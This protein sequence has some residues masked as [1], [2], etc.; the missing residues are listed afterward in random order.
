MTGP[1]RFYDKALVEAVD[2]GFRLT[3]DG[4]SIRT[5][6]RAPV[7]LPTR[8]LADAMAAEWNAQGDT[9]D[10]RTMPVTRFANA[11]LD[12]AGEH[13]AALE[14]TMAA[15]GE[16]DLLCYRAGHPEGL[17]TAQ[18]EGWDPL[19]D[20][21]RE[22]L[23]APLV[24][25]EGIMAAEQPATSL[26]RLREAVAETDAFR[27]IALHELVSLSGSLVLG[28]AVAADRLSAEEAW[29][30]SR[31]D[32]DWQVAQWGEDAEA[33]AAAERKRADFLQAA[34]IMALASR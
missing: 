21:A 10:I 31:I 4:E 19:L 17:V 8:P 23:G 27:L 3:L 2:S 16:T 32:E 18:A 22:A 33:A 25:V 6:G 15:Y 28:L 29:T 11:A 12:T 13:H 14:A 5:P 34:S 7:V 9:L 20:W 30:L 1:K 24:T 26:A